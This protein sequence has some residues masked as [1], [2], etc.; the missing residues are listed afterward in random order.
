MMV[1]MK[2]MPSL[3]RFFLMVYDVAFFFAKKPN[4]IFISSLRNTPLRFLL[5]RR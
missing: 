2:S 3:G 4:R 1:R 5:A